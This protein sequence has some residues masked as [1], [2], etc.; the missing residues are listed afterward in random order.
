MYEKIFSLV[1][2]AVLLATFFPTFAASV[3]AE[4]NIHSHRY[5]ELQCRF[6]L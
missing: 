4:A 5:S 2:A 3:R 1:M 6:K